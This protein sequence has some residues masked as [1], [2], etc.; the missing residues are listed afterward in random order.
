MEES[1]TEKEEAGAK[2]Y[3]IF[4][5][6]G[7]QYKARK[8][9]LLCIDYRDGVEDGARIE[10]GR[11]LLV[12]DGENIIVGQPTVEGAVVVGHITHSEVKDRKIEV[13]RYKRRKRYRRKRGHRQRYTEVMI[14]EIKIK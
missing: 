1:Q 14:D 7:K 5:D 13:L 6:R 10:F 11:V 4:E 8:G 9:E 12:R 3:A 2:D